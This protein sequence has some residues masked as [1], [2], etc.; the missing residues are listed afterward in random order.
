[1]PSA[2]TDV[3]IIGLVY[4]LAV[5][6]LRLAYRRSGRV[7]VLRHCIVLPGRGRRT[8]VEGH[9][10]EAVIASFAALAA[11]VV[12]YFTPDVSLAGILVRWWWIAA[13]ILAFVLGCI[14]LYS[15]QVIGEAVRAGRRRVYCRR[16]GAAYSVYNLYSA[17]LFG[18]GAMILLMLAGQFV[19][20]GAILARESADIVRIFEE[21]RLTAAAAADGP[22]EASAEAYAQALAHAEA[23]FG[24]IALANKL[25]QIQFNPMF[26]FAGTLIAINILINYSPL[27]HMFMGEAVVMTAAFTYGPLIIIGVFALAVYLGSYETMLQA[28]LEQLRAFTPPSSL[29]DWELSQRHAQMVSEISNARNIFGFGRAVGGEGGGFAILVWG[30]Q[31][32]LEKIGEKREKAASP[33]MPHPKFRPNAA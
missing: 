27:K 4:L 17:C 13:L 5:A 2:A 23:G 14:H 1:M 22:A 3:L 7:W 24:R 21:A 18:M 9:V 31:T 12:L 15:R 6:L 16:L 28:S 19:H 33:R 32:A 26:I 10:G 29:G 25:L 8:Y 20:D 30:V 11:L